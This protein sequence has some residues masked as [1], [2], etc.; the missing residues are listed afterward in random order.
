MYDRRAKNVAVFEDSMGL[1]NGNEMLR[2]AIRTSIEKQKLYLEGENVSVPE[3]RSL[4]CKTVVSKKRS[5]EATAEYAR[6]GK[7]VCVLNFAS[8]TNPGGGVTRG[9]SA[10]EECLCRCSTLYPCLNIEKMWDAFYGPHR[11]A[12]NPLYNDDCLYTPGVVV[13]KSDVSF[14]ER[15]EEADWYQVDVITC[16]APNLRS[17]PSN[18]MNP[19]A[20]ETPAE[21]E[22]EKLYKLHQRRI[23]RIF[24]I[25]AA[26]GAEILI[27]GAFGCGAFCNPPEVVA[28]AFKAVQEK[29]ASYFE[30]IEYA[31]FC[32]RYETENYQVFRKV[33][34]TEKK[35]EET[36]DLSRFLEA[37]ERDYQNALNELRAGNKQTHWMWYIFPQIAGLGRSSMSQFYSIADLNEARAY[38][39]NPVLG[40]HTLELCQVLLALDTNNPVEVFHWPDTLKF[41]SCMTLFEK[42][43]PNQKVFGMLLDKFFGGK[44]DR[45]TLERL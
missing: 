24:R 15:M 19:C 42:A 27:L 20:G 16:A 13:F 3:D 17:V 41:K 21:I 22:N 31:V 40:A 14:P 33:F 25:A 28:K 12:G 39:E 30:M 37:H 36:C 2:Q 9:S 26:N 6:D 8:S 34:E 35:K 5:F 43:D 18:F 7:K 4:V 11:A 44:R 10:Q 45:E 23:E 29:Y 1:M 32:G 38:L